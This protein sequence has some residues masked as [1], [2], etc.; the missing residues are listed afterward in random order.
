MSLNK[1]EVEEVVKQAQSPGQQI[2]FIPSKLA[3]TKKPAEKGFRR[4][5]TVVVILRSEMRTNK[6]IHHNAILSAFARSTVH[7]KMAFV[8]ADFN[9]EQGES[10]LL[11]RPP[12]FF[13]DLGFMVTDKSFLP[14]QAIY[15]FP[16]SP[17]F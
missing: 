6:H 12:Q 14:Q 11:V 7:I 15:G 13:V 2:K 16:P 3:F 9:M 17:R 1:T 8:N 4:M 5:V 10:L